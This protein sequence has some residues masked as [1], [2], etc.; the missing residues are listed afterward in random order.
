MAS[1]AQNSRSH[2]AMG[3]QDPVLIVSISEGSCW[4]MRES[5]ELALL[6]DLQS[7]MVSSVLIC[8]GF[9]VSYCKK[10]LLNHVT[11]FIK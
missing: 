8:N 11:N 4:E 3:R 9:D 6:D 5:G 7:N 10:Y 2:V 1:V